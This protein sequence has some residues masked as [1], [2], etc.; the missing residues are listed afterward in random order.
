MK[1]TFVWLA[2]LCLCLQA[3]A[4]F[5][6][7]PD[8]SG[9]WDLDVKKS[10]LPET[11]RIGSMTMIVTQ[12]E[13]QIEIERMTNRPKGSPRG[14][15]MASEDKGNQIFKYSLDGKESSTVIGGE[16]GLG[17]MSAGK[18]LRRAILTPDGKLSLTVARIYEA[19]KSSAT[20]KINEIWELA[21]AGTVLKITR[22]TE[23][24]SGATNVELYF[25]RKER[26]G[27]TTLTTPN[28]TKPAVYVG[29]ESG[30]ETVSVVT[31]SVNEAA[32]GTIYGGVMNGKASKLSIPKYP[33]AAKAIRAGGA[34][35]VQVMID[36][37]GNVISAQSVSGHPLL[38]QAAEQAARDSQFVPTLLEGTP[39]KVTGIV[40]Y[41]FAP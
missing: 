13:K 28:T 7:T 6:A 37:Q 25:T 32:P 29:T 39:V 23:A 27:T 5:A 3:A 8:F 2:V 35:N 14:G 24:A 41:N 38:R 10:N 17:N 20:T 33:A 19:E 9:L 16:V 1:K 22:Y 12:T 26:E 40:V 11:M 31:E 30:K 18:E 15:G 4:V 21:E 36:E 34:V